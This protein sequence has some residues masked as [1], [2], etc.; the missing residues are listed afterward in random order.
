[1][2]TFKNYKA[3]L[4]S[5][6]SYQVSGVPWMTGSTSLVGS[7]EDRI[8]VVMMIFE[9]ILMLLVLEGLLPVYTM[10]P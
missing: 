5:V 10:L 3:G 6:G 2:A 4:G 1:M 7:G 8:L 9:F